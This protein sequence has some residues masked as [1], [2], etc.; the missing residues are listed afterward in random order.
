MNARRLV[1]FFC[2][3]SIVCTLGCTQAVSQTIG[4]WRF[5]DAATDKPLIARDSLGSGNEFRAFNAAVT[6]ATSSLV[7]YDVQPQSGMPN[8]QSLDFTAAPGNRMPARDLFLVGS[9]TALDPNVD[10]IE[11]WTI[12]ACVRFKA[13]DGWER[14]FQTFIC[15]EGYNVPDA[16]PL[17]EN[18]LG[19]L[20]FKKRGDRNHLSIEAWDSD[21]HYVVV[22]SPDEVRPDVWYSVAAS[23]DGSVLSLWIKGPGDAAYTKKGERPF[24][25]PLPNTR[26]VW[27]IG[28]GF[29]ANQIAEPFVG[30]IDEVRFSASALKP[31]QFLASPFSGKTDR[32]EVAAKPR[33]ADPLGDFGGSRAMPDNLPRPHDPFVIES[34]GVYHLFASHGGISHWRSSDL[35]NWQRLAPVF[36]GVPAWATRDI[37]PRAGLWAPE[38]AFFSGKYHLY[39]STS[40]FGSKRSAIGLATSPTLD[41]DAPDCKWTDLG[42]VI[43]SFPNSDFNAIDASVLIAPDGQPWIAWGSYSGGLYISKLDPQTGL[44][45]EGPANFVNIASRRRTGPRAGPLEAPGLFYRDGWYYLF[46]SYDRCCAGAASTYKLLVGRSREITGPYV[47]RDGR[48]MLEGNASLVVR[49]YDHLRGPGQSSVVK[50]GDRWM[51]V[52]HYYDARRNGVPTL[53]VRPLHWD[54]DAWPLAG[55]P[56]LEPAGEK[57]SAT[58]L[59]SLMG[60][61]LMLSDDVAGIRMTFTA[62]GIIRSDRGQGTWKLDGD[63]LQIVLPKSPEAASA[64][65]IKAFLAEDRNSFVGRRSDGAIVRARLQR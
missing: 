43:E 62:D 15:R 46:A 57:T 3:L 7:P 39:Y 26:R 4:H 31:E 22:E 14:S 44:L 30:W 49:G 38:V 24:H 8:K 12:E 11:Q 9:P 29:F 28:R 40:T 45:P 59:A 63:H 53:A 27:S 51:L 35:I 61:W 10:P 55:E 18:Q 1:T 23:S 2:H 33:A 20:G 65:E 50:R 41:P 37:A 13:T 21:G 36:T 34:G 58:N 17:D 60:D 56:I 6:P 25:G 47:D 64:L 19:A 48:P 42:K 5:E 54:G 52:H 32:P 16:G